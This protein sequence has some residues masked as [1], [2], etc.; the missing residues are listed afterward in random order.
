MSDLTQEAFALKRLQSQLRQRL[1]RTRTWM[2]AHFAAEGTARVLGSLLLVLA[3]SLLLDWWLELS[4]AGRLSYALAG[5]GL[6]SWVGWRS[7]L[8]PLLLPLGPIDLAAALDRRSGTGAARAVAPRVASV[9]QLPEHLDQ[10]RESSPELI[11]A[12]VAESHASLKGIDFRR[13]LN[14]RHLGVSLAA[15]AAAVMVPWLFSLWTPST[16][17]LWAERWLQ[18]SNR[19]WP[20]NTRIEVVGLRD[21]KFIVPRGEPARLQVLVHDQGEPTEVVHLRMRSP[22]R[23]DQT[24]ALT[25]FDAGDFR[26]ELGPL[27]QPVAA[28]V[29]GGDASPATF[30]IVPLDRPRITDLRLTATHPRESAAAIHRFT[31]EEGTVRLLPETE[32]VLELTANVPIAAITVENS[33]PGPRTFEQIDPRRFVTRWTHV[34]PVQMQVTLTSRA[35]GLVSHPRPIRVE[36]LPDRA[37]RLSLRHAGVRQRISPLATIPLSVSAY[38]DF[39]IR[40][41]SLSVELTTVAGG[42][43]AAAESVGATGPATGDGL[44]ETPPSEG[45]TAGSAARVAALY[46]PKQPASEGTVEQAHDLDVEPLQVVPGAVVAVQ[47]AT[48]DDCFRGPQQTLSRKTLFRVVK[49]EELFREI[50]LRQQQLRARL[51]KQYELAIELRDAI[52]AASLPAEADRLVRQHELIRREVGQISRALDASVLEMK[53]NR[54]GGPETWELIEATV[55]RPLAQLHDADMELQRQSLLTLAEHPPPAVEPVVEQQQSIIDSLQKILDNMA[56]WDSFIDVINQLN[57]VINLETRVRRLTEEL[58]LRQ[59]ESIFDQ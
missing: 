52:R 31:G 2:R 43:D 5:L 23:R 8:Q 14:P 39:G 48:S 24:V 54:L 6:V 51:R 30:E 13:A 41:V 27:Q 40:D 34:A 50:L 15:A 26:Y 7:V 45:D 36:E 59:V 10:P 16:V 4:R 46:G 53:L 28:R 17:S 49:T 32:A 44:A 37:P 25:R 1:E 3:L 11:A 47:A 57:T 22:T 42:E 58:R 12:A 35:A 20:R 19:P 29:W 18:G 56:Q 38:D 33:G 55:L 21:G 9:L